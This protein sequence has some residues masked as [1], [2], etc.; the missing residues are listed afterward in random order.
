[1][2]SQDRLPN[3]RIL[4]DGMGFTLERLQTGSKAAVSLP[5]IRAILCIAA[6]SLPFDR[7]FYLS[8]YPDIRKAYESGKIKDLTTHFIEFGYFEGRMG[9][10]P[11][12]DE[13]FYLATYPDVA[14]ALE[15]G[16]VASA[17]EHYISSGSFEGRHA[18]ALAMET[19]K[20]WSEL[21]R[22]A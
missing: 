14:A 9:A 7:E 4:L 15:K 17:L 2:I 8:T 18:N 1:M 6:A 13:G 12:F 20:R 16:A 3:G 11:E 5:V 22:P 21:L 10:Q 19:N